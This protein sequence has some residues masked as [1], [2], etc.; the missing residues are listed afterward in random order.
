M[1]A[2]LLVLFVTVCFLGLLLAAL[3]TGTHWA[4]ILKA[5]IILTTTGV[6][7]GCYFA[8]VE[9]LGW[10]SPLHSLNEDQVLVHAVV[11]EPN[12]GSGEGGGIYLWVESLEH[13]LPPRA[14]EFSYSR[15]FHEAIVEAL[16]RQQAGTKQGIRIEGSGAGASTTEIPRIYDLYRPKPSDKN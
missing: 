6:L 1:I 8:L 10:P 5:S 3:V 12:K 4:W 16:R 15:K 14:L 13:N 2:N 11:H 9:L 7:I